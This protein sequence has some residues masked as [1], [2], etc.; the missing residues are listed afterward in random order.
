MAEEANVPNQSTVDESFPT[1]TAESETNGNDARSALEEVV[2][3]KGNGGDDDN[4]NN[5]N[6]ESGK[7]ESTQEP[8]LNKEDAPDNEDTSISATNKNRNAVD[9]D[10]H[11]HLKGDGEQS[12]Q[13]ITNNTPNNEATNI[14][15]S[16]N[17][18]VEQTH[19]QKA[20]ATATDL[21]SESEPSNINV[22][23]SP[24]LPLTAPTTT[25]A[26]SSSTTSLRA[27]E[28]NA[29]GNDS[30]DSKKGAVSTKVK[31]PPKSV[32][33]PSNVISP[34]SSTTTTEHDPD[35]IKLKFLFANRDGLNVMVECKITDSVGEVKGVL[36]SMWPDG[37]FLSF[38]FHK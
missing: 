22:V 28:N 9:E 7:M 31:V 35:A 10:S 34:N 33:S 19:E 23:Q 6:I 15:V 3:S 8:I 20:V 26:V 18:T 30:S 12:E 24:P 29:N 11:S 13:P 5:S 36:L 2:A 27:I 32:L 1:L 16:E 4:N 21:I 37:K 14:D 25:S 17:P 38:P